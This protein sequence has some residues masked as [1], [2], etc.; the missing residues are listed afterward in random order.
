LYG[1]LGN[2]KIKPPTWNGLRRVYPVSQMAG[3]VTH[4]KDGIA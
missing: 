4:K 3:I 2:I 1:I